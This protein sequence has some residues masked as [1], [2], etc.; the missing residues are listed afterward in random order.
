MGWTEK[1]QLTPFDNLPI[2]GL[3]FL[4]GDAIA[5]RIGRNWTLGQKYPVVVFPSGQRFDLWESSNLEAW[6]IVHV[7]GEMDLA[8]KSGRD[9][10]FE[11]ANHIAE[12]LGYLARKVGEDG[13]EVW[14]HDDE[15]HYLITYS[16]DTG[17]MVNIAPIESNEPPPVHPGH[18]LITDEIREKLPQLGENEEQG[19]NA[20]AQVKYFTPDSNWTW[21]ASEFDGDDL[22]FGLVIGFEIELGYF[23]L[24]ELQEAR[25]PL[26]LKIERDL[27]YEPQSLQDLREQHWRERG[28]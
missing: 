19:L 27:Y 14:G 12:Q 15:E 9:E 13:L 2:P 5:Q 20:L 21:Y 3:F 28:E 26:G 25:G 23:S 22:F 10:A 11:A 17:Q 7:F 1:E 8:Y 24:R 6:G 4:D 16:N 18:Q